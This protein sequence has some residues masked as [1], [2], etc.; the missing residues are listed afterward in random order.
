MGKIYKAY[1]P[2]MDRYV[3]LKVLKLDVPEQERRRFR[4]EAMIGSNFAHPNLVRVL[5]VGSVQEG[6]LE[7]MAMEYLRGRDI[8]EVIE[9][10][11]PMPVPLLV[12][13]F[14]QVCDALRYIH[15][16]RIVHCDIKPENIFITRDPM[17]RR[18]VVVKLI[19]FGIARNLDPPFELM[20][21][22]TGDPRYIAPEQ[23]ILNGPF[24]HRADIYALGMTLYEV[25]TCRHPF[26]ELL[27]GTVAQLLMAHRERTP[28]PPST[29]L[30]DDIPRGTAKALDDVFA[31]ACA[32]DPARRFA[33]AAAMQQTILAVGK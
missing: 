14:R 30:G 32:L 15:D 17:N 1:E 8:G 27:A 33:D 23:Q 21:Y 26:E 3:A 7:W 25:L 11:K 6:K 31:R 10:R 28:S 5:D 19:D 20:Q 18:L 16:R 2:A 12:D 29:F 4:R 22:V 9:K 24:D 13:V